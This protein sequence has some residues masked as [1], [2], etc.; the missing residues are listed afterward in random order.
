[1]NLRSRQGSFYLSV[2]GAFAAVMFSG[3]TART[4]TI[5]Q[6]EWGE[7]FNN[8]VG[9]EAEDNWVANSYTARG[10]GVHLVS[11]SLP[12]GDNFT[13]QPISAFIYQGFD[14]NDPTAG[15]GLVLLSQTSTTFTSTRGDILTIPL[16]SPV[17]LNA[18]DIF[19]A[20]VMIPGVPGGNSGLF[21]FYEDYSKDSSLMTNAL[22]RS[23]YDVGL[24]APGSGQGG[25][26]D[27]TQ[28]VSS[29][30]T[31][32]GSVHPVLGGAPGDVQDAGN[33]AL[34]VKGTTAP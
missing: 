8:S 3:A 29:N 18:G 27:V 16:T 24:G 1:M 25:T 12:I 2:L 19:Y 20:A 32:F 4:Q 23:F 17:D 21:P 33:L 13:N 7:R 15:G 34:W 26:F 6:L 22:G 30:I 9:S 31:V 5:Y 14:L 10:S 28:Q 11:I